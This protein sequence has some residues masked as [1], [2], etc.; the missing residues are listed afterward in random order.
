MFSDSNPEYGYNNKD[1]TYTL[2]DMTFS[3]SV[4]NCLDK[5]LF[6]QIDERR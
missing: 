2:S 4:K 3:E 5:K 1:Y 6:G